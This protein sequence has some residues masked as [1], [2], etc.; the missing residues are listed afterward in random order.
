MRRDIRW[1]VVERR[2][3]LQI[4]QQND[5]NALVARG[6]HHFIISWQIWP[7]ACSIRPRWSARI[8]RRHVRNR[9][10]QCQSAPAAEARC[11]SATTDRRAMA[12]PNRP[13]NPATADISVTTEIWRL[14]ELRQSI[15]N[16]RQ[17]DKGNEGPATSYERISSARLG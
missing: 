9:R 14:R 17:R 1:R 8:S 7:R 2:E 4:V 11:P 15:C 13:A 5:G 16:N 12:M 3:K 6:S 10:N